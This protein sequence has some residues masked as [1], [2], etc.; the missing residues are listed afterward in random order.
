MVELQEILDFRGSLGETDVR[1]SP[2]RE[3]PGQWGKGT[4]LHFFYPTYTLRPYSI[5]TYVI[6]SLYE[7]NL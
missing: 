5:C 3:N 2:I 7:V 6:C 1:E 4:I